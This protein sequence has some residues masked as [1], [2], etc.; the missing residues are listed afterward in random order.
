MKKVTRRLSKKTISKNQLM[1]ILPRGKENAIKS[2]VLMNLIG[3]S[4]KREV[5]QVIQEARSKGA[6]ILSDT[7]NGYYLPSNKTEIESFIKSMEKRGKLILKA[8]KSAKKQLTF[9]EGQEEMEM[10]S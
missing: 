6:V 7:T 4:G 3:L 1:S 10:N 9:L 5:G 2:D 8:T